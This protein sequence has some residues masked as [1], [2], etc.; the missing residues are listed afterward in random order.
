MARIYAPMHIMLN[1]LLGSS[2]ALQ[3]SGCSQSLA[4]SYRFWWCLSKP[5][6]IICQAVGSFDWYILAGLS[7]RILHLQIKLLVLGQSV[8]CTCR[9]NTS[10][11]VL[12]TLKCYCAWIA[13]RRWTELRLKWWACRTSKFQSSDTME[14][15]AYLHPPF[16]LAAE[17][18]F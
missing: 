4:E 2:R 15:T 18:T 10:E 11:V 6:R 9:K 8:F 16:W 7:S 13:C 3:T 5:L 17:E 1:T 14:R 12:E